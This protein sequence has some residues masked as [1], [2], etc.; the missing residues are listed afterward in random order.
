MF[1]S[2]IDILQLTPTDHPDHTG[3]TE[4]CMKVQEIATMADDPPTKMATQLLNLYQSIKDCPVSKQAP[5]QPNPT[6]G[7]NHMFVCSAL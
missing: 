2:L 5:T 3:L 7:Y 1:F 4:A 6:Q